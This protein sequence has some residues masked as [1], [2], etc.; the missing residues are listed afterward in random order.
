MTCPQGQH[1][2]VKAVQVLLNS[3]KCKKKNPKIKCSNETYIAKAREFAKGCKNK[4]S[5]PLTVDDK[6]FGNE[7]KGD[8]R[9]VALVYVCSLY[10]IDENNQIKYPPKKPSKKTTNKPEPKPIEDKQEEDNEEDED[11]SNYTSYRFFS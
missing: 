1:I 4:E 3:D 2:F 9:Y 8:Q 10:E 5:C 7:C 6:L 11:Q